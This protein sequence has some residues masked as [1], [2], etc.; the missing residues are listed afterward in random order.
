MAFFDKYYADVK[1]GDYVELWGGILVVPVLDVDG[2]GMVSLELPG[3]VSKRYRVYPDQF[4]SL[5]AKDFLYNF[6]KRAHGQ[7]AH[8]GIYVEAGRPGPVISRGNNWNGHGRLIH[9]E[10]YGRVSVHGER[11]HST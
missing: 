5:A 1:N 8:V 7:R 11:G 10:S 4:C 3:Y 6:G 9:L 2:E